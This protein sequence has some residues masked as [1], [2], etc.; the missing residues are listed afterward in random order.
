MPKRTLPDYDNPPA[1]ET[2]LSFHF[3]P[4]HW[5][6]PHFGAFW[7][8]VKDSYPRFEVHPPVG[9]FSF[10]FDA[11]SPEAVVNFPVRCW[12]INEEENRLIQVQNTRFFQNWRRPSPEA[13]YLHYD[14][15]RPTFLKEWDRFCAFA[16]KHGMGTPHVLLAEVS[17]VNHLERG[18]GW[19][20]FSELSVIFPNIGSLTGKSFLKEPE[21]AEV[22]ATF[23]MPEK[24][25]RLNIH[26]QPAIRQSD[27]KEI[28]QFSLTGSCQPASNQG[29]DL[30]SCL[31][32]CRSWVVNGF[33]DFTSAG[34]HKIWGKR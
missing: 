11:M 9:E 26:I 19:K 22:S 2:W 28:L 5:N 17:Y 6:I 1:Q 30:F 34:M 15:L 3:T 12:F 33:D 31:D 4:L 18:L 14:D 20:E 13:P 29:A 23:V 8:E 16:L 21:T 7:N 24:N 10:E 27:T 25:G 32:A